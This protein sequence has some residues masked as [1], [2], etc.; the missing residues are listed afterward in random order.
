MERLARH[1]AGRTAKGQGLV[2]YSLI[3]LAIA[4]VCVTALTSLGTT[5]PSMFSAANAGL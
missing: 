2:E 1:A 4:L 3:V 5:L